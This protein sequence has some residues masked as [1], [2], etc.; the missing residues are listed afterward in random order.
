MILGSA[1]FNG[2][3]TL[4]VL[5]LGPAM[6]RFLGLKSGS[7][8]AHK[9]KKFAKLKSFLKSY[10]YDLLK[11]C[12][13]LA[14]QKPYITNIF[15]NFITATWFGYFRKHLNGVTKASSLYDI[16]FGIFPTHSKAIF[17]KVD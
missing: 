17:E 16:I 8:M 1:V 11:V 14:K 10:F 5:D 2:V 7:Q 9:T 12:S 4:C 15:R 6:R 3:I 13:H